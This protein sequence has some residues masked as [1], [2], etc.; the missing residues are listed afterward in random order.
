[1]KRF[2]FVA[3]LMLALAT[4]VTHAQPFMDRVHFEASAAAGI[5]SRGITPIDFSFRS[6]V[7]FVSVSYL[8]VAVEDNV[9]LYSGN[10]V[11]SYSNGAG[12]GGGVGVRLL[13]SKSEKHALDV[14]AKALG[15]VGRPY[16]K[17]NSYDLSLAWYVPS[18][19]FSPVVEVG[20]RFIDSR[21]T[22]IENCSTAYLS[23][24]F[25]Y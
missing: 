2:A 19:R 4:T 20:Y 7:D 23:I 6:F 1:M 12:I 15:S 10:G 24:G 9:S 5:R 8:F 11:K 18:A 21:T 13:G 17:R 16:W 25:R 14:R 3:V 22:G